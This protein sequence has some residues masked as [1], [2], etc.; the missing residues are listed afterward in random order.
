MSNIKS[1]DSIAVIGPTASGKTKLAVQLAYKLHGQIISVDSRMVFKGMD[2]GTG[3]D[4]AEYTHQ[5]RPIIYHM[6]DL[7]EPWE[8]YHIYQFQQDFKKAFGSIQ[9][10]G[11]TPILAGGSGLYLEAVIQD[12]EYTSIPSNKE[13]RG[14]LEELSLLALQHQFQLMDIHPYKEIADLATK[15]RA[16]RAIEI[17]DYLLTNPEFALPISKPIRPFII[18]LNPPLELRRNR[19]ID[20]LHSRI[21]EGLITEV[22]DLLEKG[23]TKERLSFFGLEY[24]WVVT[25]LEGQI[26]KTE[27]VTHLGIAIQQFSKRQMTYFRKMEKSGLKIHWIS[28]PSEIDLLMPMLASF[29]G[30]NTNCNY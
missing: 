28:N 23:V 8:D 27:M 17:L 11:K 29:E 5:N 24:K 19:I 26:S 20:R 22:E 1:Y 30:I 18:G 25:F 21:K 12:F 7:V 3:K 13:K 10:I 6:I 9:C 2:I 14:A 16:I 15:K 4:L